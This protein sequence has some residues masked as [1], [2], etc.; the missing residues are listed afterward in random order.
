MSNM[1]HAVE[2]LCHPE[3]RN[4]QNA[5]ETLR[6]AEGRITD[7]IKTVAQLQGHSPSE[8]DDYNFNWEEN[9]I[10]GHFSHYCCGE[11]D[12]YSVSVPFEY[13][14]TDNYVEVETARLAEIRR[15]DEEARLAREAAEAARK[16]ADQ[17][18]AERATY[19]RLK[20]KF[21]GKER[22]NAEPVLI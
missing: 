2:T 9:C 5:I 22:P 1:Q 18:R 19:E 10:E 21:E 13:L 14:W 20:K 8:F 4:L 16:K 12:Y 11:T 6:H 3:G 17:E 15:K 7:I